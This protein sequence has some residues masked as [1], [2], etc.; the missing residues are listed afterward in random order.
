[1]RAVNGEL[2]RQAEILKLSE[3]RFRHMAENMQKMFWL[4]DP[5][6]LEAIW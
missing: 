3:E 1:M 6:T 5:K 2:R 4:P